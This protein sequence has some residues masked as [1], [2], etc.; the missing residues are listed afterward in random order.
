M[1]SDLLGLPFP[2]G[3]ELLQSMP[4]WAANLM[5][6]LLLAGLLSASGFVLA[7]LGRSPLWALLLLVPMVQIIAYW[8]F[9]YKPWPRESAK[10]E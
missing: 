3:F 6:G 4:M 1:I 7:R 8:V 2:L 9:A 10:P 5:L